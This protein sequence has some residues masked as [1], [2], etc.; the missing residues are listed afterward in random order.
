MG[1]RVPWVLS[2]PTS[3]GSAICFGKGVNGQPH[4]WWQRSKRH[5]AEKDYLLGFFETQPHISHILLPVLSVGCYS[6]GGHEVIPAYPHTTRSRYGQT[7]TTRHL[8]DRS[9]LAGARDQRRSA[10]VQPAL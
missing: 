10:G 7:L 5:R 2:A 1:C 3:P 4:G 6:R 9:N 8:D